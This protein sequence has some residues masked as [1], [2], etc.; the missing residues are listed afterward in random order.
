MKTFEKP[1]GHLY[2]KEKEVID[3]CAEI[4]RWTTET[5]NNS[6]FMER[7][8]LREQATKLYEILGKMDFGHDDKYYKIYVQYDILKKNYEELKKKA[9]AYKVFEIDFINEKNSDIITTIFQHI[10]KYGTF[11]GEQYAKYVGGYGDHIRLLVNK[12]NNSYDIHMNELW[13]YDEHESKPHIDKMINKF[14][15]KFIFQT[16]YDRRQHDYDSAYEFNFGVDDIPQ[17]DIASV[18][19]F[20]IK[21]IKLTPRIRKNRE[22]NNKHI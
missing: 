18:L 19:E 3:L 12:K 21:N 7:S 22:E 17:K 6:L 14:K 15:E 4:I 16:Y 5:S 20:I 8:A 13:N 10:E 1:F 11:S 2:G 9:E